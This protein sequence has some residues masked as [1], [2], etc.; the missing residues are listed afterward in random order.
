PLT[1]IM[2]HEKIPFFAATYLPKT[3]RFGLMGLTELLPRLLHMWEEKREDIEKMGEELLFSLSQKTDIDGI[4]LDESILD[5][6]YIS[7]LDQFDDAYGGFGYAPK[8]PMPHTIGY[9][10]RYYNRSNEKQALAMAESTLQ[11]MRRGGIWDHVGYG[12]HRY[13]TDRFWHVPHF[14]KMLYDQALLTIAY[15]EAFQVTG[16]EEYKETAEMI[17][18]YVLRSMTSPH[19]AF[20]SAEDADSEGEEGKFYVWSTQEIKNTVLVFDK[21]QEIFSLTAEG[22]FEEPGKKQTGQNILHLRKSVPEHARDL[23]MSVDEIKTLMETE[24]VRLFAEREQRV[25]PSRDD[26]ILADWNGLMIAAFSKAGQVFDMKKY[27]KTAQKA[28][29]FI[30]REMMDDILYHRFCA[31][32]KAIPGFLEDYAFF[33][34]GLL[35]LYEATFEPSNLTHALSLTQYLLDHFWDPQGGFYHT[36]DEGEYLLIRKKDSFDG[37]LPSG[38]SVAMMNLLRLSR[39]TG[40]TEFEEKAWALLNGFSSFI[41]RVPGSHIHLL[42][43]LD[44]ALGPTYE[45]VIVGKKEAQD[46]RKMVQA[47]E[48]PFIPRKV[49]IM[50]CGE[51]E[52]I[53]S[54]SPFT[55]DLISIDGKST[56]Y[57][58]SNHICTL[59]TTDIQI[60]LTLLKNPKKWDNK[61]SRL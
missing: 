56:S 10:L 1:I 50:K 22:N 52:R 5:A 12:F 15:I 44:F 34:W 28:A 20:Y 46:T 57:V 7:L 23:G 4:R 61:N 24:R 43:A 11:T 16:K 18:H 53:T 6:A 29:D 31:G 55:T 54:L 49:V 2:A 26:K 33:V 48:Q 45:V 42:T 51:D 19:G 8:F 30:L 36:S 35:E 38:N 39:I 41:S 3:R 27:R 40:N 9:L 25:H 21:I 14:E 32:E 47:I 59:P 17:L 13:S 60:M 37:A 58:C